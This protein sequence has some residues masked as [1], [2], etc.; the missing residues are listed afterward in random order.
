MATGGI[1]TGAQKWDVRSADERMEQRLSWEVWS[2][3]KLWFDETMPNSGSSDGC[4]TTWL[5][6]NFWNFGGKN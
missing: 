1:E 3:P 4:Q 6:V 2:V 5:N